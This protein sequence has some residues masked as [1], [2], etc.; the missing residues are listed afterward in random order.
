MTLMRTV[1]C[2]WCPTPHTHGC[3]KRWRLTSKRYLGHVGVG[4]GQG[5]FRA[6]AKVASHKDMSHVT[7][8]KG[9][10]VEELCASLPYLGKGWV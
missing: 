1:P 4:R 5:G 6:R 2:W 3:R 9:V 7:C 10:T 8:Q